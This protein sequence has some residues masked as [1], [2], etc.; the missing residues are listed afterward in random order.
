M[1]T[2]NNLNVDPYY[3]STVAET[4]KDYHRVLF[5][6]GRAVQARELSAAQG[7]L[8]DQIARFGNHVFK[9]GSV[10]IPGAL[11][12][13]TNFTY[14]KL[15]PQFNGVDINLSN[16]L[17]KK[18]AGVTSGTIATVVR[19]EAPVG[20]DPHTVYVQY[21]SGVSSQSFTAKTTNGSTVIDNLSGSTTSTAIAVG[22]LV[23]GVGI[24]A[25][26]FIVEN[27]ATT[28]KIT[29]SNAAT[30]TSG[31]LGISI[32]AT[33]AKQFTVGETIT[34]V[35]DS[36]TTERFSAVVTGEGFGSRASIA[37]GY[38]FC[39]GHFVAVHAQEILLDKYG[40]SPT[41]KV[42]LILGQQ[43]VDALDDPDLFDPSYGSSNYN[44]PGADRLKL[45]LTLVKTEA[46][47]QTDSSFYEILRLKD[48][49]VEAK[50][51][52]TGYSEID[53]TL[54]NRTYDESGHYTVK[55]FPIEI[56]EHLD[57]GTN[58][59]VYTALEGGDET[60]M[61]AALSPG[62]AYVAGYSVETFGTKY[63][64]FQKA[65][66][67]ARAN[68]SLL[69]FQYGNFVDV[70]NVSGV[71]DISTY[72]TVNFRSAVH[73]G[74]SSA[75]TL[76]GT[77]KVRMIEYRSG[78]IG[79]TGAVYRLWLFDIA[80]SGS[81]TFAANV[82]SIVIPGTPA[83]LSNVVLTT[84]GVAVLGQ[85]GSASLVFP[86]GYNVKTLKDSSG[87]IDVT[88]SVRRKL[89]GTMSGSS[90]VFAAGAN[91]VFRS[92]S[93]AAYHLAIKTAS[94]TA[95]GNGYAAGDVIDLSGSGNSLVLGGSPTGS[96]ITVTVP[97]IAGSTVDLIA[98]VTK[99]TAN[100]KT[101]TL[102]TRTQTI[103]TPG[104]GIIQL[105]RCDIFSVD[106]VTDKGVSG[107]ANID[108]KNRY[109]FDD[110]QRDNYYDRGRLILGSTAT[111]PAGNVVVTYK[112]FEHSVGD[113]FCVDSYT[114]AIPY[115]DIPSYNSV[116]SG[117]TVNLCD[118]ID[119]RPRISNDGTTFSVYSETVVPND[120][121]I[122]DYDYYLPRIDKVFVDYQGKFGVLKGI[123]SLN[124]KEPVVPTDAMAL[125][126]LKISPYTRSVAS[127]LPEY[128]DNRNF[129]MR[130][131]GKIVKRV[132]NL[133]YYTALSLLEKDTKDLFIDD[134]TGNNRFKNGFVVDNFTGHNVGDATNQQ[135]ACS[136][137]PSRGEMRP[138]FKQEN[139][140]LSVNS[141]SSSNYTQ[142]GLL[143][144]LPYTETP[145]I[146]QPYNSRFENINPFNVFSWVGA[147]ELDPPVDDWKDTN[148]LPD[149]VVQ[150]NNT[151]TAFNSLAQ[152]WGTQWNDWETSWT[153]TPREVS[154]TTVDS[155]VVLNPAALLQGI[156]DVGNQ[157]VGWLTSSIDQASHIGLDRDSYYDPATGM[158]G[159][160]GLTSVQTTSN[161][162]Y[163][164]D[165]GQTRTG[166]RLNIETSTTNQNLGDRIVD[167]ST[168]PFMRSITIN[169]SA[170][171][172]KPN[173]RV[174][175]FFDGVAVS[176]YCT[177][178]GGVLGGA[179]ISDNN[180]SVSGTFTIP[181]T[182]TVRFRTGARVFRLTNSETNASQNVDSSAEATFT[183]AGLV[184]NT[185]KTILS[186][187]EVQLS[188]TTVSDSRT[189]TSTTNTTDVTRSDY[190]D[191]LAQS[192][193]MNLKGGG[194]VSSIDI[195][196]QS[197]D[198]NIPVELQLREMVNG[199]P[200]KVI[201][202]FSRVILTP[203]QVQTSSDGTVATRF[204]FPSP[205]Y[206][207]DSTEYCFVLL[208]NS[209][210]YN[211]W[212]AAI[213][214]NQI[215]TE[216]RITEQ[217][218]TG[219]M[220]KSQNASTWTPEQ[221]QDVKFVINRCQ[222]STSVTSNIVMS[223]D[224]VAAVPLA[225]NSLVSTN[226][227]NVLKVIHRAH[228]LSVGDKVVLA[229]ATDVND[230]LAVNINKTQTVSSVIDF[231][232][233][234]VDI[235]DS[236]GNPDVATGTGAGGGSNVTAVGNVQMNTFNATIG[237]LV[238]PDTTLVTGVRTTDTAFIKTSSYANFD[239]GT[240]VSIST[241][242]IIASDVN[243]TF[244][245]SGNKSFDILV[246][247]STTKDNLSPVIDTSRASVVAVGNRINSPTVDNE[248]SAS[249]GLSIAKYITKRVT[250]AST[251]NDL[252]VMFAGN[253][254]SGSSVDVYYKAQGPDS[255]VLFDDLP[256]TKMN[257][258]SAV[259]V[260][261]TTAVFRDRKY[262]T[263]TKPAQFTI[264]SIKIVMKSTST[265]VVPRVRDF[266]AIALAT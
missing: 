134:G 140:G 4:N 63:I 101:K 224:S 182:S 44:A 254:M 179:L 118:S 231:D 208:A 217:P 123:P 245:M 197:K 163:A 137:D 71:P 113:Y 22:A 260:S 28:N 64:E 194:F 244:R 125:Y 250:L 236:S 60:K 143:L 166:V 204:T 65:R 93:A 258:E 10:V 122:L 178:T 86:T 153:G 193:L 92:Y 242:S 196:F 145:F 84:S 131:I 111:A 149:L 144:T 237:N 95:T 94:A 13:D 225:V 142:T 249:S 19:V 85:V 191:P 67:T 168:A 187:Q 110:G 77:A 229:G 98:T 117:G 116:Q 165:T 265:S 171:R 151:A 7:I 68:N 100:Y 192:F 45:S 41:Y 148:S 62:K 107:T 238:F 70:S 228:G 121:M 59:G 40:N 6:P 170:K 246:S 172:L 209:N 33:T 214:E 32:V 127:V 73:G 75:G 49:A 176:A 157:S 27:N 203:N 257:L 243:Q 135:Y 241:P 8:Q 128:I 5:V 262:V 88:Y 215:G 240:N 57:N 103:T 221:N 256:W 17:G 264:F 23:T 119:F 211:V 133:E 184:S 222:F 102:V 81:N 147:V 112:Y 120:V 47:T 150:N 83:F 159:S 38:Y 126:T 158:L 87:A 20:S 58:R 195:Y 253:V 25:G 129:T 263:P 80:M 61:V 247:M 132:E 232:T 185:Q 3:D 233:Y 79:T 35:E 31:D 251:S 52:Q 96:Q 202:P 234:T 198:T 141:G 146:T 69:N 189:V 24:P 9:E 180:G 21:A 12:F 173:T 161:V 183:A 230:I 164:T 186:T 181:N 99:T 152:A 104:S 226:A 219:S 72:A 89:T 259:P 97:A 11:S 106:S 206:L 51:D 156:S 16:F 220:F 261:E 78:T 42:G 169:F 36:Q 39:A 139:V 213:G 105:D 50:I 162:T 227:S 109:V 91:E 175:P 205:V 210:A 108:V 155:Q 53:K 248:T 14:A 154:R 218:Y 30:A 216:T 255:T 130:D 136:V 114:S 252:Y 239:L 124:P 223:N 266:R 199:S 177:P 43:L 34:T 66:D 235:L 15:A 90:V 174:Y 2:L 190:V 37:D 167:V 188:T 200:G 74:S 138:M 56:R 26:T 29:L 212:T 55:Y 48:G 1:A 115:A 46:T 76:T 160:G 207:Q 54:A 82:K 201:I 18:V